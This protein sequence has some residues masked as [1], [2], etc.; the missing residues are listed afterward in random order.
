MSAMVNSN[1]IFE[2]ISSNNKLFVFCLALYIVDLRGPYS[3]LNSFPYNFL[4]QDLTL[5]FTCFRCFK[6]FLT[7]CM[8][9][10]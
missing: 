6:Q 1:L 8:A 5:Y 3:F 10:G 2:L 7:A 4:P 9:L